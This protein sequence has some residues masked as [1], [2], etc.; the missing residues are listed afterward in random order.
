MGAE[1][2]DDNETLPRRS[3]PARRGRPPP[4]T[5]GLV[6]AWSGHEDHRL[7]EVLLPP[8][9]RPGPLV[10]IGRGATGTEGMP[11]LQPSRQRPGRQDDTGPLASRY[12]SRAQLHVR[13]CGDQHL[14]IANVGAGAVLRNGVAVERTRVLPGDTVEIEGELLLVCARRPVRYPELEGPP[15]AFGAAD[16]AGIVGES[17]ATYKLRAQIAF[18]AKSG[19]HVRIDGPSGS[20]KELVA[21]AVHAAGS[22]GPF[23]ARS[24]TTLPEG[25]VDAELFGN[26]AGYP[27]PG[28]AARPGLVGQADGGTLFLD[29]F[30]DMPEQVQTHLLRVLDAGEYQRLGEAR[31]RHARFR[32]VAASN[33]WE[34]VRRE[35]VAARLAVRVA[36]P[37]LQA[38]R[39]DIPLLIRHLM[40]LR[41][42]SAPALAAPVFEAGRLSITPRLVDALVRHAYVAHVRELDALLWTAMMSCPEGPL[43]LVPELALDVPTPPPEAPDPGA[44]PPDALTAEEIQACLD[45]HHGV[46]ERVWRELGLSSRY[47]LLRL[48]KKHGLRVTRRG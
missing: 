11:R 15:F 37:G 5:L 21:R 1:S 40:S 41:A 3:R 23:V 14:E 44:T 43:D 18:A 47:V 32:L 19:V 2:R 26:I 24:A 29:E 33:R 13:A 38:R 16:P 12:L 45:L 22:G 8:P 39:E 9:G 25:L 31:A 17:P 36:V 48:I 30:A 42:R 27:N 28:M 34:R 35:D 20:G 4:A 7:G 46:Q 6:V 10:E